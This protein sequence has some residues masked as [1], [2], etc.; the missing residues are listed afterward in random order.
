MAFASSVVQGEGLAARTFLEHKDD[1]A[2]AATDVMPVMTLS[3]F[4]VLAAVA[5]VCGIGVLIA[6]YVVAEGMLGRY[7][8]HGRGTTPVLHRGRG[9]EDE[10]L[11]ATADRE[12]GDVTKKDRTMSSVSTA[13]SSN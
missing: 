13:D 2:R 3:N 7:V 4:V 1:A 6:S 9:N 5:V 12:G 8:L 10:D 11:L